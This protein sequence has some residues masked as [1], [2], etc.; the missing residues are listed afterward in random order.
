MKAFGIFIFILGNAYASGNQT[1]PGI[2]RLPD[3][4]GPTP[5]VIPTQPIPPGNGQYNYQ[6]V[7]PNR[8]QPGRN[9]S[10]E[11]QSRQYHQ[12]EQNLQNI[13][14]QVK[15]RHRNDQV[16]QIVDDFGVACKERNFSALIK[17]WDDLDNLSTTTTGNANQIKNELREILI[18]NIISELER[19]SPK[20]RALK[21]P[22]DDPDLLTKYQ[23]VLEAF[24]THVLDPE[25][26]ELNALY[27]RYRGARRNGDSVE[28]RNT[29]AEYNKKKRKLA[30]FLKRS[31]IDRY[32]AEHLTRMK[33]PDIALALNEISFKIETAKSSFVE[34][35]PERRQLFAQRL[36]KKVRKM[37]EEWNLRRG[38]IVKSPEYKDNVRYYK[39]TLDR[40]RQEYASL[41]QRAYRD[42]ARGNIYRCNQARRNLPRWQRRFQE[43]AQDLQRKIQRNEQIGM[44]Y[45]QLEAEGRRYRLGYSDGYGNGGQGRGSYN[46]H[47]Y[48]MG[49]QG[50]PQ[51]M[52]NH[53]FGRQN[54]PYQ[55]SYFPQQFQQQPNLYGMN[56]QFGYG[57]MRPPQGSFQFPQT[58]GQGYGYNSY[59]GYGMNG[60]NNFYQ[61]QNMYGM[62]GFARPN[63]G[64]PS[65]MMGGGLYNYPGSF[66][67]TSFS[68]FNPGLQGGGLYNYTGQNFGMMRYPATTFPSA[69]GYGGI[70]GSQMMPGMGVNPY[71]YSGYRAGYTL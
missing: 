22:D 25:I 52:M 21:N 46:P 7:Q 68:G 45:E 43:L 47:H 36:N 65:N 4:P 38:R 13:L 23:E 50:N 5:N 19:L 54:V 66:N 53:Q 58:L 31:A 63:Y 28:E 61:Q 41:Q 17:S 37:T 24:H 33:E 35:E 2:V 12:S 1:N 60:M 67:N 32:L 10:Y 57:Q 55:T 48:T 16:I 49:Y 40:L 71:Q 9:Y 59:G 26:G 29:R 70:Y 3:A 51:A 15:Q 56:P 27:S 14:N 11:N 64:Y 34:E 44:S 39:N 62:N 69:G 30:G 20:V 6:P 18:N 42:C 8:T